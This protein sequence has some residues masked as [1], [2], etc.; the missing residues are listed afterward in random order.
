M[1]WRK[2]TD[3]AHSRCVSFHFIFCLITFFSQ[4]KWLTV[5]NLNFFKNAYFDFEANYPNPHLGRHHENN[6][7]LTVGVLL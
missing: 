2:A 6:I 5:A 3:L 1:N 4:H 7:K